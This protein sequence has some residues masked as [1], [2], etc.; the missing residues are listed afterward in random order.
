[1]W[2]AKEAEKAEAAEAEAA[3]DAAADAAKS[4]K[5]TALKRRA[6]RNSQTGSQAEALRIARAAAS[7]TSPSASAKPALARGTNPLAA[8]RAAAGAAAKE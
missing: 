3:V 8:K 7:T 5:K 1:M 2:L 6:R 4:V